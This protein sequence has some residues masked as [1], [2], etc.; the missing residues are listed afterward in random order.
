MKTS[1][2]QH[3]QSEQYNMKTSLNIIIVCTQDLQQKEKTVE[4][5]INMNMQT[6]K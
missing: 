5:T 1:L 2:N 6:R 4:N 3:E